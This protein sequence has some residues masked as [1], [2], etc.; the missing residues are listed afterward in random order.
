MLRIYQGFVISGAIFLFGTAAIFFAVIPGIRA[1]MDLYES[2]NVV[3]KETQALSGKLALLEGISEDDIRER[4][5]ILLSAVTAEKSVPTIFNT[6][7]GLANLSGVSIADMSLTSPGSLATGAASRQSASE[8]KIGA[9]SLPFSINISGT[10]DQ[11]RAFVGQI[12]K[13][14]RIFNISSFDLSIAP[15]G[16]VQVRLALAA[17]YQP[18][19]TK[20][21]SVQSPVTP[22]TQ[23]EEALLVKV[24]QY[25]DVSQATTESLTPLFSGG[26]RDPF[27]R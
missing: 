23:K 9:S 10:Y 26:N 21:G 25:P 4:L 27:A 13:V 19:P 1:T 3:K 22:L 7:E 18:L 24:M 20:V 12:N 17:F 11:M 5:I 15:S 6:V 16:V 8:K 14:R 2:L